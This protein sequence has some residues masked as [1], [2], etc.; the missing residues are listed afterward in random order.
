[1][2]FPAHVLQQ[3]PPGLAAKV[4]LASFEEGASSPHERPESSA[5]GGGE[6]AHV[7]PLK[8]PWALPLGVSELDAAL[9][10]GGLLRGGVVELAVRGV[11]AQATSIALSACQA[12]QQEGMLKGG[13][14]PWCAFVDPT[15]SLYAPGVAQAGVQLER[16]LVVRPS[17][18]ALSRVALR[19]VESHAF[20]VVVIDTMGTLG[21]R[22]DV[23]LGAWPRIVRRLSLAL[24]SSASVVLLITD[25][26]APR[27]LPLP[28]AQRIELSRP[29]LHKI[30]LQVAKDRRGRVSAPRSIAWTRP[31]ANNPICSQ[32]SVSNHSRRA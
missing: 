9:P 24:E 19:L 25:S 17:L 3:L 14:P 6:S 20:A 30:G 16:L 8:G 5:K 18:E 11:S 15:G 10:D 23:P 4:S 22:L 29:R 21:K 32:H 26:A 28:V 1:M 12:A 31:A 13:S 27:P 2:A 7:P